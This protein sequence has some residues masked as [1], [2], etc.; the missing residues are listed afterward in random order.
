MF[1]DGACLCRLFRYAC[2]QSVRQRLRNFIAV[3]N[4]QLFASGPEWSAEMPQKLRQKRR[5]LRM[6]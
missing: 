3:Q 1:Y 2:H 4:A 6:A 5:L